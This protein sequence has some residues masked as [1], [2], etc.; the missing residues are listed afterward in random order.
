MSLTAATSSTPASGPTE[1]KQDASTTSKFD[2]S[3]YRQSQHVTM[4][5]TAIPTRMLQT[6]IPVRKPGKKQ[7][8]RVHPSAE[9]RID[10][11]PTIEDESTGEIYLLAAD[12]QLP[13]DLEN[14]VDY[15]NLATA[16][17]ADGS[18]F[19][20]HFKNSTNSW[21]DSARIAIRHA[22]RQ[23]VR[24]VADRSS[25]GYKLE[26]PMIAPADPVWPNLS[27]TEI[28][29]TAFGSRYIDSLKHPLIKKLRGD[30]NV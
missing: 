28:L 18:L 10:G 7:F 22:S 8:V 6:V 25:N 27:I 20:W 29:E 1:M 30:F 2:P 5:E 14:K 26:S 3:N 23:W 13:A 11:I 12:L 4:E 17:T 19:L 16:I 9:F 24:V 21:S 15:L